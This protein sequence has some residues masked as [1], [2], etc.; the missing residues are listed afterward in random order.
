MK[1]TLAAI[2]AFS[3][4]APALAFAQA[5]PATPARPNAQAPATAATPAT[6]AK[7]DAAK[8]N[9]VRRGPT[10]APAPAR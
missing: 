8:P 7:K 1:K 4:V 5:T 6:P 10:H 2:L 9:E 3:L